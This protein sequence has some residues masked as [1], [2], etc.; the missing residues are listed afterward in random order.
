MN[1]TSAI[2]SLPIALC[3]ALGKIF[4]YHLVLGKEKSP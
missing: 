4:T 1:Y 2:A 3:R